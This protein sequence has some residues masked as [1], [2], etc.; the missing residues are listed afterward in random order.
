M[1]KGAAHGGGD[2]R[3]TGL[4]EVTYERMM[5]RR[6]GTIGHACEKETKRTGE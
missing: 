2:D 3:L 4:D 6:Q 5:N 1:G